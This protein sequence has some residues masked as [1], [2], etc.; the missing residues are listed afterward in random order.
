M[1]VPQG[2]QL[3]V[4][5]ICRFLVLILLGFLNT[6]KGKIPTTTKTINTL[7]LEHSEIS[8]H[9]NFILNHT[10]TTKLVFNIIGHGFCIHVYQKTDTFITKRRKF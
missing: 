9:K 1:G 3:F 7:P 4:L 10:N 2:F 8:H 5:I 6:L